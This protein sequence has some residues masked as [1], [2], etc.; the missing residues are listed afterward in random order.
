MK[1]WASVLWICAFGGDARFV[2]QG[3]DLGTAGLEL[4]DE[5]RTVGVLVRHSPD[6]HTHDRSADPDGEADRQERR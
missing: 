5:D 2:R 1:P 4:F 6:P 3:G